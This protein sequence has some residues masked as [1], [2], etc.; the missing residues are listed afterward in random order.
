MHNKYFI[1]P[2]V[3]IL[4]SSILMFDNLQSVYALS[5]IA[6]AIADTGQSATGQSITA[7]CPSAWSNPIGTC[8]YVINDATT[9]KIYVYDVTN[10]IS[11]SLVGSISVGGATMSGTTSSIVY[12]ENTDRLI[13]MG[14]NNFYE[15]DYR[16]MVV[17]RSLAHSANLAGMFYADGYIWFLG[18]VGPLFQRLSTTA[19]AT[20]ESSPTL[21][22]G[23]NACSSIG[24]S[25]LPT[26]SYAEDIDTVFIACIGATDRLI[27]YTPLDLGGGATNSVASVDWGADNNPRSPVYVSDTSTTGRVLAIGTTTLFTVKQATYNSNTQTFGALSVVHTA[28]GSPAGLVYYEAPEWIIYSDGTTVYVLNAGSPTSQIVSFAQ[29]ITGSVGSPFPTTMNTYYVFYGVGTNDNWIMIDLSGVAVG[30]GGSNPPTPTTGIDCDLPENAGI[31]TC[32]LQNEGGSLNGTG[33]L[34]TDSVGNLICQ[35][36]F[37]DC[38]ANPDMRT[39]GVGYI[40]WLI[41]LM[42][43]VGI[44]WVA[45]RG[46]ITQI[47]TFVWFIGTIAITIAMTIMQFIDPT[48]LIISI[49]VVIAFAVAKAKGV[50]GG[51][52]SLMNENIQ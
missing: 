15:I 5:I 21:N 24:T 50:L 3:A 45:S 51:G 7:T 4:I 8:V 10:G 38:D 6:T 39:N 33:G 31:L 20:I 12:S 2:V 41:G 47:P 16:N 32:R 27:A 11:P 29:P 9:D 28:G 36:G 42:I 37:I 23:A 43:M 44:F 22:A 26:L 17:L 30:T 48:A 13:V 49:V 18:G 46:D 40:F 34:V 1:I 35:L 52:G 25:S 14:S 19:F